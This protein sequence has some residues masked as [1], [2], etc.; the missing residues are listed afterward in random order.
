MCYDTKRIRQYLLFGGLAFLIQILL[1]R[2]VHSVA[3]SC[4]SCILAE[5]YCVSYSHSTIELSILL[6]EYICMV[7]RFLLFMDSAGMTV[8]VHISRNTCIRV[9]LEC[10][11][12]SGAAGL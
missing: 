7:S 6:S 11:P 2:Q 8:L 5:V 3:C 10:F 9:V 4:C 12:G 1:L